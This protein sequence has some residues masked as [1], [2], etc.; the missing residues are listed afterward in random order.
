[1]EAQ[2]KWHTQVVGKKEEG[3]NGKWKKKNGG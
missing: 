2:G 1:M 3:R